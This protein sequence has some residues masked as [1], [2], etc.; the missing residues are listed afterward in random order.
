MLACIRPLALA[1]LALHLQWSLATD[2]PVPFSREA[3]QSA[4]GAK[5]VVLIVA[6]ADYL[7]RVAPCTPYSSLCRTARHERFCRQPSLSVA[8]VAST[9]SGLSSRPAARR[10][11]PHPCQEGFIPCVPPE[12]SPV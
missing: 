11:A 1:V 3:Y 9:E 8:V 4:A 6:L 5:G 12:S 7:A 10:I 2:A